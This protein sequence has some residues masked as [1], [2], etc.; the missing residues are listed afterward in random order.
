MRC[1]ASAKPDL[2]LQGHIHRGC[3][4]C[5]LVLQ[6]QRS[7]DVLCVICLA[8]L[9]DGCSY[10]LRHKYVFRE[11]EA[12]CLTEPDALSERERGLYQENMKGCLF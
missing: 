8:G 7:Y 9:I 2:G 1:Q 10:A 12:A 5:R 3:T 11:A 6:R 4:I